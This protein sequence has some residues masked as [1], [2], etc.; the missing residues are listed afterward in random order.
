MAGRVE[1]ASRLVW[2][3]EVLAVDPGHRLLEI[4]CGHGV[5][6]SLVCERLDGGSITSRTSGARGP[7]ASSRRRDSRRWTG[8]REGRRDGSDGV[9]LSGGFRVISSGRLLE[10]PTVRD[11]RKPKQVEAKKGRTR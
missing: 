9:C 11:H 8:R 2:A 1:A 3:M 6:V 7:A 5:A 10:K 4:G